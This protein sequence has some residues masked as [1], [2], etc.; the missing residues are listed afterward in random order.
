[1]CGIAGFIDLQQNKDKAAL[2]SLVSDMSNTLIHRGPNG[3]GIWIDEKAGLALAHRRL[4]ILDLSDAGH[5]PMLSDSERYIIIFNGE[6]YNFLSLKKR[7]ERNGLKFRGTSDTEVLLA[8]IEEWS[9]EKTLHEINGMFAFAVWDRKE[10]ILHLARDRMGKKPIYYGWCGKAFLF[11]SELKAFRAHPSFS[12]EIDRDAL[13]V[14]TRHNYVPA[15]WSIYKG[16]YKLPPASF[17]SFP[18]KT[19]IET[20][21]QKYWDITQIAENGCRNP[22]D[23]SFETALEELD[24]ILSN[25]VKERMISDVPLGS[26]LSG[27]I[28]SS[29][30]SAIMQKHASNPIKTYCIGFEEAG[31]NEAKDAKKIAAYLGTDHTELYVTANEARNVI[32]DL[33]SI[34]DEPFADPSQIPTYH[35]S[36]LA[37]KH[38]TVALSG[39]GGDEGFAGYKRYHMAQKLG[40]ALFKIPSPIRSLLAGTLQNIPTTRHIQKLSEVMTACDK[41][42]LYRLLMSYWKESGRLLTTGKEPLVAM[43]DPAQKPDIDNFIN[44]MMHQDMRAYLPDDILVKTDRTS[45]A[46]SLE[47]RAPLLDYKV[48]EYAWNLPLH[49][50]IQHGEGKY[51]LR[52]LLESYIPKP[53]FDRPKQGFGIPHGQWLRNPLREWAEA[54]LDEKRLEQEGFFNPAPIRQKWKEHLSRN[55]DWSYQIWGILMFQAWH[56]RW[57]K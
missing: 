18:L 36:R 2:S 6:I 54:L 22:I 4:A 26:F 8:A 3:S 7:L 16:I 55:R 49:M 28:D 56:E 11:A 23:V 15:P 44:R 47:T 45:M 35:V 51:I 30:I 27:G 32:P 43:N 46:V 17:L 41:D 39:D 5:Q 40:N 14:Y 53:L 52:S 42:D 1:M 33:P 21:P 29:L 9:L 10:Q 57:C 19:G 24:V 37:Q 48:I 12:P 50:K 38:V 31:Y 20:A 13:A 25:A 34:F